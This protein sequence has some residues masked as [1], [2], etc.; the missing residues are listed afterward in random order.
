[1]FAAGCK[2]RRRAAGIVVVFLWL[3]F[4]GAACRTHIPE[5]E[6]VHAYE[7]ARFRLQECRKMGAE[8]LAPE[9]LKTASLLSGEI[10]DM[11]SAGRCSRAAERL[12]HLEEIVTGLSRSLKD[13][14][15]DGD[16][17]SNY[18]E[19]AL[20]GTSWNNSDSDGDGYLDGSEIMLHGTDPLDYCSVPTDVQPEAPVQCPCPALKGLDFGEHERGKTS[21]RR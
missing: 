21:E 16:G 9:R 12:G 2:E 18:A 6:L 11:L 1:M 8:I 20:Y 4:G 13:W 7:L 17:L 10:E 19:Y 3:A 5:A 15:E 14:D